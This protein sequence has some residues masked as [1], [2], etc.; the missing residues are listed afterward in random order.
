MK[1]NT[2]H[3]SAAK[4]SNV[5]EISDGVYINLNRITSDENEFEKAIEE[6]FKK[7]DHKEAIANSKNKPNKP[8]SSQ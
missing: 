2:P 6:T 7:L 1:K 4:T 8:K 5:K 3:N